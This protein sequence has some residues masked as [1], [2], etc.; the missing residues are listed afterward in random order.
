[1]SGSDEKAFDIFFELYFEYR[2]HAEEG[3]NI[4]VAG[5]IDYIQNTYNAN[6]SNRWLNRLS[7]DISCEFEELK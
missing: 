3:R 2:K 1:L 4:G 5:I 7:C 6:W